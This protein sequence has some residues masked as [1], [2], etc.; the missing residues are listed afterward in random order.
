MADRAGEDW[1]I[2]VPSGMT[3]QVWIAINRPQIDAGTY[4]GAIELRSAAGFSEQVPVRLT[5]YPLRFPDETTLHCGGWSY[6]DADTMYGVTPENKAA[7]VE[8]LREHFVNA[9]WAT[10]AAMR[11][12]TF[13][14]EGNVVTEPDTTRFD[15]WVAMWPDAKMYLVYSAVESSF[16]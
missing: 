16:D 8:H 13:D 9:P 4:E 5:V 1:L 14:D 6:T 7:I 3:R 12:G 2:D 15:D 10:G 11:G